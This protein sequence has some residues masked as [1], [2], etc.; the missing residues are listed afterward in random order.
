MRRNRNSTNLYRATSTLVELLRQRASQQPERP[1]YC[2]LLDGDGTE[3][4]LTYAELDRRARAL[5]VALQRLGATGE[6]ALLLYPPGLDYIAA[7]FGCLYA[8]TVAVPAYPP[9]PNRPSP[10]LRAILENALPRVILTTSALRAKL[11]RLLPVPAG[12]AWLATDDPERPATNAADLAARAEEWLDPGIGPSTL[13]FLQYTSGSTAAPKGVML[14]HANLLHNL[15]LIRACFAQT[16]RERTV[17]W[18]PPYHDMGLIG[19]IL[20]PLYAG[21]P[22]TLL[23]PLTFLQ[24]PVRWLRAISNTRA[25]T[26]GGPN[27]AYDLCVQKVSAEQRLELDLSSWSLAFN[28]AEPIRPDTLERFAAAFS[29][30]GFRREAF[31][32]CYGLAEATLLVSA[33]RRLEGPDVRSFAAD[34]A[35]RDARPRVGCG[36]AASPQP[37]YPE[38]RIV[39]AE[40]SEPCAPGE[41]G[42][43]WVAGPSVAQGYWRQPEETAR[44]F[45]AR[46]AG[47]EGEAAGPFLRTGDLGFVADGELFVTGRLKDLIILRG[48]NHYP[49]DIE[50]TVE[51][52]HAALRPGCGAAFAVEREGEERLVVAVEVRRER[53]QDDA[54]GIIAAIRRAIAEEHEVTPDAVVLL[55]TATLPKTSSGKVQRHACRAAYLAGDLATVA[56]W[57]AGEAADETAEAAAATELD[58]ADEL[59]RWLA[60]EMARR[61][62][63]PPGST[64]DPRQPVASHA[65][66]SL[67]DRADACNRAPHRRHRRGGDALLRDQPARPRRRAAPAAGGAAGDTCRRRRGLLPAL[68]R[69]TVALVSARARAGEPRVQRAQCRADPG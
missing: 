10:R 1:G 55:K 45:G 26:S 17:L 60:G 34:A 38:I 58:D 52:S 35:T 61:S 37:G 40:S 30:C 6:R 64:V 7:F 59:V 54:A 25:T 57:T 19:G 15:E 44:V 63:M 14:S 13:A 67:G 51:H 53:R 4:Q 18:L 24:Q 47:V 49:Q 39:R 28:G 46:P 8:G 33:G 20:E 62:G 21:Y 65:L 9:R 32:P 3:A 22:V 43:I 69:P 68:P 2:F 36:L 12:T 23:S 16:E 29:S 27:F 42:E 11:E 5:G 31:F 66:D 41:V 48:R 56:T 50:L